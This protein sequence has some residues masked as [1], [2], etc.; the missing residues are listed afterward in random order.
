LVGSIAVIVMMRTDLRDARTDGAG[1]VKATDVAG[2]AAAPRSAVTVSP[3]TVVPIEPAEPDAISAPDRVVAGTGGPAVV[4]A[5]ASSS[6]GSGPGAAPARPG[7]PLPT[8][9]GAP[10]L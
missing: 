1:S 10:P 4:S 6:G 7:H 5:G 9:P 3:I 8:G 2:I